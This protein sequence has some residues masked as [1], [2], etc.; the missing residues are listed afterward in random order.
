VYE[1]NVYTSNGVR[2]IVSNSHYNPGDSVTFALEVDDGYEISGISVIDVKTGKSLELSDN[3]FR[4]PEGD[5][6]IEVSAKFKKYTVIFISG[7]KVIS[8]REYE[9]GATV[10]VPK[11]PQKE[12]DKHYS[13]VFSGWSPKLSE[14][15]TDSVTYVARYKTQRIPVAS[16][17]DELKLSDSIMN[18]LKIFTVLMALICAAPC[19]LLSCLF[20]LRYKRLFAK[21]KKD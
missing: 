5:V 19:I 7:G 4:M 9:H 20:V 16:G 3:A 10:N 2:V 11:D 15:V 12:S 21:R 1:I 18:L 14:T 8:K 13:Y 17:G 6:E